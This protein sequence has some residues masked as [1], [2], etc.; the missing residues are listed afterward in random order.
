[1]ADEKAAV[2][3]Q[4]KQPSWRATRALNGALD[5]TA[6]VQQ[7]TPATMGHGRAD[8]PGFPDRLAA[9]Y[10]VSAKQARFLSQACPWR[11][12]RPETHTHVHVRCEKRVLGRLN[13]KA[14]HFKV[15][16]V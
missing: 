15:G 13:A 12:S 7:R 9:G 14:T 16:R 6:V 2:N 1:M 4:P 10:Q 11:P 5:Q 3:L 8:S